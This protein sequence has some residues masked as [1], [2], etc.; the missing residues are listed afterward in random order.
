MVSA[1]KSPRHVSLSLGLHLLFTI[2]VAS[3]KKSP[4]RVSLALGLHLLFTTL[5]L[6]PEWIVV[7]GSLV[8]RDL[9]FSQSA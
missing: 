4:H 6:G 9:R 5:W 8:I 3:V 1:K 2:F 7:A